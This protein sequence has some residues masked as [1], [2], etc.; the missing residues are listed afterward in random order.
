MNNIDSAQALRERY[1]TP[2]ALAV[3][4]MKEALDDY[5]RQFIALS[6]FICLATASADGQ[7][8]VS[9][10]GD[11][12]GFVHIVD[13]RRLAIPDRR[14]NNKVESFTNV[15]ENPK[16]SI[17]FF[18]PGLPETL[19]V[20]GTAAL[21]TDAATLQR[22]AVNGKPA[23]LVLLFD[24]DTVYFHCGKAVVRSKLWDAGHQVAR[25]AFP[26]FGRVIREQ[27]KLAASED[28]AQALVDDMYTNG[29]Y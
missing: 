5:H 22:H 6:P 15:V 7:P 19:R 2:G 3:A 16:A 25:D 18:V 17:I 27:A 8:F 14:G 20:R 10:K 12:P 4:C 9:P 21:S 11:A 1:G 29:L 26:P 13:E 23:E 24:I 28:E